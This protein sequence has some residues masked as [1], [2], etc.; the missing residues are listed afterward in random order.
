[1]AASLLHA[2]FNNKLQEENEA[3]K[4]EAIKAKESMENM[5]SRINNSLSTVRFYQQE[6]NQTTEGANTRALEIL[7][8]IQATLESFDEQ[9]KNSVGLVNE[10]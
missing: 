10:M 5:L 9:N 6:L 1:S 3:Q 8:S 7:N 4:Q 2:H